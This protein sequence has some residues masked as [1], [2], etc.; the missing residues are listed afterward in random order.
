M[1]I[2]ESLKTAFDQTYKNFEIIVVND[3]STDNFE[4]E[5]E[6]IRNEYSSKNYLI[7]VITQENRGAPAARNRGFKEA[8]GEFVIFWDADLVAKPEMLQKMKTALD[9]HQ[10]CS[11]A[12]S[13]FRFG[14]KKFKLQS[15]DAGELKKNNYITTSSLIRSEDFVGFDESVKKFQDW[16]LWLTMLEKNK[17]GIFIPE[18]LFTLKVSGRAGISS[19]LPKIAYALPFKLKMVKKYEDAKR[20]ILEK[21]HLNTQ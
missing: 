19:W 15:F 7:K 10:E 6:K 3:G 17:I 14:W 1:R 16:D 5:M 18:V 2:A 13:Q 12:Y 11:Y 20:I 8:S 4:M 9:E 21:H